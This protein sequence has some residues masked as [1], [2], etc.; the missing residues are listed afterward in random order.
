LIDKKNIIAVDPFESFFSY[1]FGNPLD[2]KRWDYV[3]KN[4]YTLLSCLAMDDTFNKD[5]T[6][7]R[8]YYG[9]VKTSF[10]NAFT[11]LTLDSYFHNKILQRFNTSNN[12]PPAFKTYLDE[13]SKKS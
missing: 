9:L 1:L 6:D 8:K 7:A 3:N 10:D 4:L 11:V 12:W 2:M 5:R 13:Q